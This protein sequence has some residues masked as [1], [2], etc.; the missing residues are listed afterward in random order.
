MRRSAFNRSH[1]RLHAVLQAEVRTRSELDQ[2]GLAWTLKER[3]SRPILPSLWSAQ[4]DSVLQGHV[5]DPRDQR[6]VRLLALP[7]S[8]KIAQV[9]AGGE[10][11]I[12]P[13]NG[14]NFLGVLNADRGFN[15]NHHHHVFI[16]GL[17]V[18]VSPQSSVLPVALAAPPFR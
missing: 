9:R 3:E 12:D 6:F 13:G 10:D 11:H 14:R 4:P 2:L 17:T 5:V 18:V 16:A 15:H 1:Y 8:G 7:V